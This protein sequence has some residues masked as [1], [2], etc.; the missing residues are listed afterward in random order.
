MAIEKV[1]DIKELV[2]KARDYDN[3]CEMPPKQLVEELE[4]AYEVLPKFKSTTD[5]ELYRFLKEYINNT[6]YI[7]KGIIL[8]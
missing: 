5:T 4:K 8:K 1:E 6:V 3:K 7:A 2:D